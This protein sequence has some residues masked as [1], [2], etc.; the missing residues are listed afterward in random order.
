ME[1]F[2]V[3]VGS[4]CTFPSGRVQDKTRRVRFH[5]EKLGSYTEFKLDP[6]SRSLTDTR[7]ATQT[8]YRTDDGRFLVH[9][10][11]WSRWNDEPTRYNL[12]E[13]EEEDLWTG[14]RFEFLGRK[15]GLTPPMSLEEYLSQLAES[16]NEESTD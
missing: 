7:G 11:D 3:K 8:L 5:G 9:I 4:Y 1:E 12:L 14:G 16:E 2:E 6:I 15:T 10:E 13:I